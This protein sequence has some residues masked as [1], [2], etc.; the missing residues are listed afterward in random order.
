MIALL[1][2]ICV[3]SILGFLNPKVLN[4]LIIDNSKPKEYWRYITHG[5]VHANFTHLLFNMWVFYQFAGVYPEK[6]FRAT[7]WTADNIT[8]TIFLA[9]VLI[10]NVSSISKP[11]HYKALGASAGVSA[12]LMVFIL[13]FPT[14]SLQLMFIPIPFPAFLFGAFYIGYEYYQS[15]KGKGSIDH[16]AHLYGLG[17][18]ALVICCFYPRIF[19]TFYHQ[20]AQY[21]WH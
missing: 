7:N 11:K 3:V 16:S 13:F 1:I 5:F 2:I 15:K 18:G 19:S 17:A 20:I 21:L 8:W 14:T 9:G 6:L 12:V 10:G 4:L